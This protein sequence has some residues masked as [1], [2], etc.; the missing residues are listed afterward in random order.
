VQA[1]Q[2]SSEE[3]MAGKGGGGY[4]R[5]LLQHLK[6]AARDR[7]GWRKLIRVVTKRRD[8]FDGTR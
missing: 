3:K 5:L 1:D 2:G 6:E 4:P 8:R 7:D